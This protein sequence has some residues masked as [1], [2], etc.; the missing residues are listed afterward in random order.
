MIATAVAAFAATATVVMADGLYRGD[1]TTA[2]HV[3]PPETILNA[4]R[5][6]GLQPTT[7]ALRR[8]PYYVLHAVDSRGLQMRV[9]A[10]AQ[11]GDIVSVSPLVIPRYDSAPRI[12][13]V[14]PAEG[15]SGG[16]DIGD[17]ELA[18]PSMDSGE[19]PPTRRMMPHVRHRRERFPKPQTGVER[20]RPVLPPRNV[21]SAP[22][23]AASLTPIHPTSRFSETPKPAEKF[24]PPADDS[25][26]TRD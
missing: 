22:P 13:H 23:A 10:D 14:P 19:A 8:G 9:V 4:V 6:F 3:L 12:I 21:L 5:S 1:P 17:D 25:A 20:K 24:A 2:A 18:A 16:A 11:L 15:R 7:Q 26:P